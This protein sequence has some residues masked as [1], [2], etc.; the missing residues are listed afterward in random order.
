MAEAT[1]GYYRSGT[2]WLHRRSPVTKLLALGLV[3]LATFAL[4]PVTLTALLVIVV[5]A[6]WSA[7]L[8]R[9]MLASLRIPVVLFVSIILVNAFF[10]PGARD[11]IIQL[12]PAALTSEG[13]A[14]GVISAGRLLVV[15]LASVLFLFTTL[16]DDILEALVARG[17]SHR[18]AFVVL[19][20]VQMVP[21]M[22]ASHVLGVGELLLRRGE[23]GHEP[24]S[25][26]GLAQQAVRRTGRSPARS[27][28]DRPV[29]SPDRHRARVQPWRW[30]FARMPR[31]DCRRPPARTPQR[32]GRAWRSTGDRGRPAAPPGRVKADRPGEQ[33]SS[34]AEIGRGVA[35]AHR[36]QAGARG[37]VVHGRAGPAAGQEGAGAP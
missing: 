3:L 15:F 20:V 31:R 22:Q 32:N 12:G 4:P 11:V 33:R 24:R 19:S 1:T 18:L 27:Y 35:A 30:A 10:F 37:G 26:I 9:P 34:E 8:L 25:P 36:T 5:V 23:R 28:V 21:R 16:A 17:V 2:S 14:F 29:T 7:G 6:G 13:L